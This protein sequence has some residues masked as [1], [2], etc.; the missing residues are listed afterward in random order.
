MAGLIHLIGV[1]CLL[2]A[3][4]LLIVVS[5]SLP[6][7]KVRR[8]DFSDPERIR[9][10]TAARPQSVYFLDVNLAVSTV[11]GFSA[12]SDHLRFGNW[13]LCIGDACTTSRL[14]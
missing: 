11:G 8:L 2:A 12:S 9:V 3:T 4:V 10:L 1:F 7:W 6:I 5:V 13:G 14:G